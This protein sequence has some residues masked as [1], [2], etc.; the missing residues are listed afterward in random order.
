MKRILLTGASGFIGQHA[1][2]PLARLGYDIHASSSRV[3]APSEDVT[4]HRADLLDTSDVDRL[5]ARIKPTH[6]LHCAWPLVPGQYASSPANVE[7]VRASLYLFERF[8]AEGGRHAAAAGTCFEYDWSDGWLRETTPL[9]PS[10]LYGAA[11][12]GLQTVASA[13]ALQTG[14]TLAWGRIFFLYGPHEHPKRLVASVIRSL[15]LGEPAPCSHGHQIRDFLHV[16]DVASALVAA[17]DAGVHGPL[18]IASGEPVRLKDIIYRA[19]DLIGRRDLVRLGAIP[20]P[21]D[22]PPLIVADV[23]T[24]AGAT[25][26]S[27]A[28]DLD[29]GLQQTVAW[30]RAELGRPA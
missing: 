18:N 14:F 4:W 9:R 12:A 11:K 23:R 30:W 5:V 2:A 13:F 27:P 15:L 22:D 6:L 25:R 24:L 26:W 21:P 20:V 7:W 28:Y 8:V 1:V 17:L 3:Q 19:A 16:E 10:T 29:R